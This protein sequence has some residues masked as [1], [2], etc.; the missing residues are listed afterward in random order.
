[1]SAYPPTRIEPSRGWSL[2][3]LAELWRFRDLFLMLAL[4]DVKLRY[5]QTALGVVWVVLQPLLA[6]AIFAAI[7]G[8]LAR[9]PSDGVPYFLF[10]YGGLVPWNLFAGVLQRAG[11]SLVAD[12]ALASKVYFPRLIIPA[13][14]GLAV[15]VDA[16]V[17]LLVLLG[18][19]VLY[20]GSL[21][22]TLLLLPFILLLTLLTGLGVA[23]WLAGLNVYYRDFVHVLPFLVQ[24]WMYGSPVVYSASIVPPEWLPLYALNP[25]VGLIGA[26]RW[27]VGAGAF[28]GFALAEGLVV[29]AIILTGG[30][31]VFRRVERSFADVV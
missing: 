8:Y 23:I 18:L 5:K 27:A 26:F 15:L 19:L 9:M 13:A 21:T 17:A 14:S 11:N 22:P 12:A 30:A 28:P 4:R 24:V 31:L 2:P 29:S 16:A 10:V 7:F 25:M 3:D 1:L 20:G 6:S